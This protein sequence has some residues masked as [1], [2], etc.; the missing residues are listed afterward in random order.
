VKI[1]VAVSIDLEKQEEVKN[2]SYNFMPNDND[3]ASLPTTR[4]FFSNQYISSQLLSLKQINMISNENFT[5]EI[6]IKTLFR[7]YF[8]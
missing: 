8:R 3:H 4:S 6:R 1:R 2:I 7:F 5:P